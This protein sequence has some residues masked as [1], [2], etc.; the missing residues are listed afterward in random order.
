MTIRQNPSLF[1]KTRKK[2][3]ECMASCEQ[4][5][6]GLKESC[7]ATNNTFVR[8]SNLLLKQTRSTLSFANMQS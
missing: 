4:L 6:H 7:E 3:S 5:S 8:I 2:Y 1:S